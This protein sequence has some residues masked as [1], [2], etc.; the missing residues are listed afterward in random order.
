MRGLWG[1]KKKGIKAF[2]SRK[3]GQIGIL[4]T[5]VLTDLHKGEQFSPS[6][7]LEVSVGVSTPCVWLGLSHGLWPC[8]PPAVPTLGQRHSYP[9]C[10]LREGRWFFWAEDNVCHVRLSPAFPMHS[11]MGQLKLQMPCPNM[12]AFKQGAKREIGVSWLKLN[13][14][15]G[16]LFKAPI[17]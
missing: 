9:E 15:M 16:L 10:V 4:I 12:V 13:G 5:A 17:Q 11:Q 6:A 14:V 8:G 3:K 1:A 2:H 7:T